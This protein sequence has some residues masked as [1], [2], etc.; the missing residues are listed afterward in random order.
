MGRNKLIQSLLKELAAD[1]YALT[2][3]VGDGRRQR[4]QVLRDEAKRLGGK[5]YC[6]LETLYLK[7]FSLHEEA[8]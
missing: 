1:R 6:E 8:V 5:S 3:A 7:S 4:Q 2:Q